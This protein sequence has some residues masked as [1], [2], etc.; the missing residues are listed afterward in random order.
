MINSFFYKS[1]AT[2][3]TLGILT[4]AI[5]LYPKTLKKNLPTDHHSQS[6]K[7]KAKKERAWLI[8]KYGTRIGDLL[9][10]IP[11]PSMDQCQNQ[12]EAFVAAKEMS[13]TTKTSFICL[14]AK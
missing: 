12:G 10:D 1:L 13:R 4:I 9:L 2:L 3:S 7:I 11:M 8:I 5:A 6:S 14:K